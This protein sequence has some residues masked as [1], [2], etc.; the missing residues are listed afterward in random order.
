MQYILDIKDTRFLSAR[1]LAE[2]R[3]CLGW[4]G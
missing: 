2:F 4:P 1:F 3:K